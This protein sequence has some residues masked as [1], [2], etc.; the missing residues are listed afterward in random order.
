MRV[1]IAGIDLTI[2]ASLVQVD[3]T[4]LMQVTITSIVP[5]LISDVPSTWLVTGNAVWLDEIGAWVPDASLNAA[6]AEAGDGYFFEAELAQ[7]RRAISE[8][9]AEEARTQAGYGG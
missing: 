2:R 6:L 9:A 5:E 3:G 4:R 7:L 1:T 8:V